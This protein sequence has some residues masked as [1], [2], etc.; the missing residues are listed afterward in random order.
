MIVFMVDPP[1]DH[2]F[3]FEAKGKWSIDVVGKLYVDFL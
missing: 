2:S 3:P 1:F